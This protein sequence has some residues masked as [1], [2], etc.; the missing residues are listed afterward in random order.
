MQYT[1]DAIIGFERLDIKLH[2]DYEGEI[3]FTLVRKICQLPSNKAVLYIHGF[4]D[5]FFQEELALEFNKHG[6]NFYAIDLRKSGRSLL[7]HQIPYNIRNINEYFDD[8]DAAIQQIKSEGNTTLVINAHSTGGLTAALYLQKHKNVC[9]ALILNSPFL[10]MNKSWFIRRIGIPVIVRFIN[11]FFPNFKIKAGFSPYYGQSINK[12]YHGEWSYNLTWKPI[13]CDYITAS[14]TNAI[15]KAHKQINKGLQIDCPIL[16]MT[17]DK[18]IK[19]KVWTDAFLNA[20]AVLNVNDIQRQ[21]LLLGNNVTIKS[22]ED[23]LHD[24]VL[25][26]RQVRTSVYSTI[27][28]WLSDN[29]LI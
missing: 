18:S 15:R 5:Y 3:V 2:H 9:D 25:S 4:Q 13:R 26:K 22:I 17:S 14:W 11:L 28:T 20:D 19:G 8:I 10:S 24:L 23:G 29:N 27:F 21:A 16:V 1:N 6:F 12:N 7:P